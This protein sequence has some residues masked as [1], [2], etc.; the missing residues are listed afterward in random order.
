LAHWWELAFLAQAVYIK[1]PQAFRCAVEGTTGVGKG[2]PN[3]MPDD[4]L[5]DFP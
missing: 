3:L 2:C 1:L 5:M 4:E